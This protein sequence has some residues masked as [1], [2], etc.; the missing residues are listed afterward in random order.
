MA[1]KRGFGK[2]ALNPKC[3]QFLVSDVMNPSSFS[4]LA[5]NLTISIEISL[6]VYH[7]FFF[8]FLKFRFD[9]QAVEALEKDGLAGV[10]PWELYCEGISIEN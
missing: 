9:R 2:G 6:K 4:R 8:N 1:L 10:Q 3:F 7:N 5:E